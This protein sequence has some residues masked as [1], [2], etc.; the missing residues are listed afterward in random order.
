MHGF[1][2]SPAKKMKDRVFRARAGDTEMRTAETAT[3]ANL[4]MEKTF[5]MLARHAPARCIMEVAACHLTTVVPSCAG[6][7]R[8]A[9]SNLGVGLR[10]RRKAGP[11][12][13]RIWIAIFIGSTIGGFVPSLWGGETFVLCRRADGAGLARLLDCGSRA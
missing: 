6:E 7:G 1:A 13:S 8:T 2:S 5:R 10:I 9:T 3:K 11:M 4:D 12:K